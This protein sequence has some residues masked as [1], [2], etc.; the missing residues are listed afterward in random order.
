MLYY[1]ATAQHNCKHRMLSK[2]PLLRVCCNWSSK[3]CIWLSPRSCSCNNTSKISQNNS[4]AQHDFLC[5][6]DKIKY[7][8]RHP[9]TGTDAGIRAGFPIDSGNIVM[10]PLHKS[11]VMDISGNC[12]LQCYVTNTWP[13]SLTFPSN[14]NIVDT[15][16]LTSA[17]HD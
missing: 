14:E 12:D 2:N 4:K 8:T 9:G 17:P 7:L 10:H 13:W 6:Q 5:T 16:P 15:N 11:L 3:K 1:P